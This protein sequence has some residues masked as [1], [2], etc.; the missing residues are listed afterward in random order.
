MR[1]LV[2]THGRTVRAYVARRIAAPEVDD[3]VAEVFVIAWR[4]AA[5][6]PGD[7]GARG[8]LLAIARRTLA[9]HRRGLGRR[10]RLQRR[11]EQVF[12]PRVANEDTDQTR[13][14]DAMRALRPEDREILRLAA[15]EDLSNAEIAVVLACTPATAAV[16]L[17]RA[18]ARL[19]NQ[20]QDHPDIRT[21][22]AVRHT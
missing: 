20:L 14:L 4:K 2:G 19:R 22:R 10:L 21:P 13:V 17:S 16:R 12:E 9:N 1:T 3:V 6:V 18:R 7:D 11:A 15:W 5:T 8:Y